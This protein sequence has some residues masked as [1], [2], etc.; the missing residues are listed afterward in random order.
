MTKSKKEFKIPK[1]IKDIGHHATNIG[2]SSLSAGKNIGKGITEIG[3]I[4]LETT[5]AVAKGIIKIGEVGINTGMAVSKDLY[6]VGESSVNTGIAVTKSASQILMTPVKKRRSIFDFFWKSKRGIITGAADNDPSG[7]VTYT[8]TGSVAGYSLL[9]LALLAWPLLVAVEEMSARV[10]I[11]AKKGLNRIIAENF[12]DI[13]AWLTTVIIVVCNTLTI[14]ADIA[15]MADV[16]SVLTGLPAII[17]A[18]LFGLIFMWVLFKKSFA[19]VSRWLFLL[20]P[21]FLLYVISA[22][23]FDVPWG[24]ALRDTFIPTL[25]SFNTNLAMVAVGFLGTTITPFLVFWE[26]TQE[27]EE[28]KQPEHLGKE[29]KGVTMGM[30][31]TQFITFFVVVAAAAAFSGKAHLIESAKDAALALKPLGNLAFLLFS[32]GIIGSGLIAIPVLAASTGYTFADTL[33]IESGLTKSFSRAKGFYLIMFLSIIIGVTISLSGFNPILMLFYSQV[34]NGILMPILLVFLMI[35][36]NSKKIL[37]KYRN[38]FWS[39]FWGVIVIIVNVLFVAL[40]F[41]NMFK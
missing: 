21:V 35:I 16:S 20:T 32:V 4:G 26:T 25:N 5:G 3:K 39:N 11:V 23:S 9:W 17:F 41:M 30:L 1:N 7:I 14:G 36:S 15:A 22:F 13:W 24:V 12:G 38:K 31:F 40:M 28:R 2:K 34:L 27:I 33:K 6:K 10:G 18:I 19:V 37:G 8:Q 29:K